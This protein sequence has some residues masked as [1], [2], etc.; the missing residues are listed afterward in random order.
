MD[1]LVR[2]EKKNNIKDSN[3]QKE[4]GKDKIFQKNNMLLKRSKCAQSQKSDSP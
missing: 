2:K 1:E 3:F 4:R